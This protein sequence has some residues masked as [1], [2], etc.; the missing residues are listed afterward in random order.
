MKKQLSVLALLAC[1]TVKALEMVD[2]TTVHVVGGV[3][4]VGDSLPVAFGKINTNFVSLTNAPSVAVTNVIALTNGAVP[5]VT[6]LG[7]SVVALLQFGIPAGAPGTNFVTS[8]ALTNSMFSSATTT[9]LNTNFNFALS[10]YLGVFTNILSAGGD[11]PQY[12]GGGMS[13]SL[14]APFN[15][16]YS[17]NG[18]TDWT[19]NLPA[20]PNILYAAVLTDANGVGKSGSVQFYSSEHPELD[21]RTNDLSRQKLRVAAPVNGSDAASKD[22]VDVTAANVASTK[23]L[24]SPAG[25]EYYYA[26]NNVRVFSL[27]RSA[28]IYSTNLSIAISGT[29]IVLNMATTNFVPGW[30]VQMATNL[31]LNNGFAIFTNYTLT[32]NS[33]VAVFTIPRY[34]LSIPSFFRIAS[35]QTAG[36]TSYWPIQTPY[37]WFGTNATFRTNTVSSSTNST[38]GYGAGL[39]TMDTNYLYLSIGT[40]TWRRI[41]IPTNTW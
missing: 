34:Q 37:V 20:F 36:V 29:N 6:N 32:T 10:N 38:L 19:T 30:Q 28:L 23:W 31:A 1:F 21:G 40:N 3:T 39:L 17:T 2:T 33:G 35:P 18:T 26:P 13:P 8:Y 12:G 16:W 11:A 15:L 5:Y 14:S 22:Y 7:N 24:T 9:L 4:I 25:D 27:F 41:A